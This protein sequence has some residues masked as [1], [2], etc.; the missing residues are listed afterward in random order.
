MYGSNIMAAYDYALKMGAHIVSCSFGPKTPNFTPTEF[1]KTQ[2]AEQERL[3]TRVIQPLNDK[4]VLVVAAAGNEYSN[5]DGL[6]SV[7]TTYL[8]CTVDLPNVLCVAATDNTSGLWREEQFNRVVGTNYGQL[9]VDFA[10]PGSRILSTVPMTGPYS[11]SSGYDLKTGSSMATPLVSGAAAL[12][13]SVLGSQSGNYFQAARTKSIILETGDTQPDL[14]VITGRSLNAARAVQT[15]RSFGNTGSFLL[16]PMPVDVGAKSGALMRILTE[17]YFRLSPVAASSLAADVARAPNTSSLVL[18]TLGM[19]PFA[20]GARPSNSSL[21]NFKHTGADVLVAVRGQLNLPSRGVYGLRIATSAPHARIAVTVGQRR[22]SFN[23]TRVAGV[24]EALLQ[25]DIAP[26]WYDFEVLFADP[27]DSI[28]LTWSLPTSRTTWG[29][30]PDGWLVSGTMSYP[31]PITYMP[32]DMPKAGSVPASE[33]PSAIGGYHILWRPMPGRNSTP[34]SGAPINNLADPAG[35]VVFSSSFLSGLTLM[36]HF[37][38]STYLD[39]LNF[40]TNISFVNALAG[41]SGPAVDRAAVAAA[42][43]GPIYGFAT[44]FIQST[45]DG[46]LSVAFRVSCTQCQLYL[47]GVLFHETSDAN[48]V[49]GSANPPATTTRITPCVI[50]DPVTNPNTTGVNRA[51]HHLQIR[52]ATR[53]RVANAGFVLQQ[54]A[55]TNPLPNTFQPVRPI[56]AP[57]P[58][59]KASAAPSTALNG[60]INCEMWDYDAVGPSGWLQ[61]GNIPRPEDV[62]PVARIRMPN[63][64]ASNYPCEPWGSFC[65]TGRNFSVMVKDIHPVNTLPNYLYARCWTWTNRGLKDGLVTVFAAETLPT[66]VYL[67]DQQVFRSLGPGDNT[68]YSSLSRAPNSTYLAGQY[69]QL[70]A[71]EWHGITPFTR[72]SITEGR[73]DIP[74]D[75]PAALVLDSSF[76]APVP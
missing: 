73:T 39:E 30:L 59:Y 16:V 48:Y 45:V 56:M 10:A 24:M 76:N 66:V 40:N 55:C 72:L 63:P 5:L 26:G 20:V 11:S 15:A 43:S 33:V 38:Y 28:D 22:L 1:H 51:R 14:A 64:K 53:T 50:L 62:S 37:T 67:G 36:S 21:R 70:L 68:P 4:G 65:P 61:L 52:F 19:T 49:P 54:T 31:T 17:S 41:G 42:A 74:Y 3:Y 25:V 69:R 58:W 2:H 57:A 18:N 13:L 44:T 9:T 60:S 29:L 75:E 7:G 34:D 27:S 6:R 23:A 12:V 8:P 47:D 35:A 46:P 71:V 32:R